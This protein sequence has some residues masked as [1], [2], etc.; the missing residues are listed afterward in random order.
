MDRPGHIHDWMSFQ[1]GRIS[2]LGSGPVP[3]EL[4]RLA[5]VIDLGAATVIPVLH[6][7]HVHLLDTG[8]MDLDVDASPASSFDELM[9]I[10]LS[11]AGSFDGRLLRAHSFD[12]DL[13]DDGRYPTA[14]ELDAVSAEIPIF[15]KRRDGHSASANTRALSYLGVA[16][17]TPGIEL[18]DGG[19]PTGV[20]RGTAYEQASR[21]AK[22][23][24]SPADRIE[25]F[26]RASWRAVERGIGVVHALAGSVEPGNRD[27]ELLLEI[28][29]SLPIDTVVYPQLLDIDRVV[30]LG[31]PRVGGCILLDGSFSSGTAALTEPYEDGGG[32]GNLYYT[33]DFLTGFY[34]DAA[35]RGLQIAVHALG[36]RAISQALS[37]IDAA[38]VDAER[39]LRLRIEH[40]ELPTPAHIAAMVR[41]G[42]AACVQPTFEYLWGGRDAMYERRLGPV[43]AARSNPFRTL[44]DAGIRLAGGSDSYVTP[45]DSLLGIHSAV[46]RPNEAERLS[47][48]QAVSLFTSG[49]AWLSFDDTR[50][51]T[52]EVGKEASFT[53]LAD[54]PFTVDPSS[55]RGIG[56][57]GL[58]LRGERVHA[59]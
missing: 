29:D 7:A 20:L 47:V 22:H 1:A 23:A 3:D 24:L 28:Q 18:D 19:R 5:D 57:E 56:V 16:D 14:A 59:A 4:V 51:G 58:F 15:V 33:D 48:F 30:A 52:L 27:I 8:L 32:R 50:R 55:I 6:D 43:R 13:M 46:N 37:A 31:L 45:M 36:G 35:S 12:P 53:L 41:L 26:R 49:A 34:G 2:A 42:V 38:Q 25:C 17:G 44:L 40:C 54:D 21:A 9:E 11:A 39:D 10:L